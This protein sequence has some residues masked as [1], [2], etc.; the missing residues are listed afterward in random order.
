MAQIKISELE[1]LIKKKMLE[2]GISET[3]I[4]EELVDKIKNKVK[5][6]ANAGKVGVA[7]NSEQEDVVV[8]VS[9]ETPTDT[10]GEIP[11]SVTQ[12]TTINPEQED[13]LKKEG[14]L[15][16]KE[17]QISEKEAELANREAEL[18]RK[19]DELAFK[20][21]LPKMVN[22][23]GPEKVFVFDKNELS[24]GAEALSK[25]PFRLV[26][27]PDTKKSMF[28]IWKDDAK[29]KAE[30]YVVKFEKIGEIEFNPF[31]GTSSL[32]EKKPEPH[33]LSDVLDNDGSEDN[34]AVSGD[35]QGINKA[36]E[37][38]KQNLSDT[39]EP[40]K[41]VTLPMGNDMGLKTVDVEVLLQKR[42]DDILKN[43]IQRMK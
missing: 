5:D 19:Q 31:Q 2:K 32:V 29:K 25:S 20:P 6:V 33:P 22:E 4:N 8:D 12:N 27:N 11:D 41:D 38:S 40:V 14:E 3:E 35:S 18:Q 28:E 16:E 9:Q 21:E 10:P 13:V 30:V 34:L 15:E 7:Q 24:L 42:V 43:Y 39:V 23:I 26:S 37:Q 17:R 36:L 1:E